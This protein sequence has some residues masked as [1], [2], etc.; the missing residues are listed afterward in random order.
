MKTA[1]RPSSSRPRRL[2]DIDRR[3][4]LRS[5]GSSMVGPPR[6]A[7]C[8]LGSDLAKG[9]RRERAGLPPRA[10]ARSLACHILGPGVALVVQERGPRAAGA[11]GTFLLPAPATVKRRGLRQYGQAAVRPPS[12]CELTPDRLGAHARVRDGSTPPGRGLHRARQR[13][14][15]FGQPQVLAVVDGHLDERRA[16]DV[17]CLAEGRSQVRRRRGPE[18]GDAEGSG[19]I[20]EVGVAEVD[21]EGLSEFVALLPVDEAVAR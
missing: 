21:A 8:D 6:V 18:S 11:P 7:A 3:A 9:G 2:R 15:P 4:G 20:D 17:E 1:A 10:D 16:I 19:E 13:S 5:I 12:C 14:Q